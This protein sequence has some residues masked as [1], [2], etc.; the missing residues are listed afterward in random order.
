MILRR[1]TEH[2]KA[3]NWFAVWIDFLIVVVGVF[4]GLQVSNWN[5]ARSRLQKEKTYLVELRGEVDAN[6]R[7]L[8]NNIELM[9]IVVT[10]GERAL[11]FLE[12]D[13]SCEA[14]C[15]RL[16]VD[17][18]LASQVMASPITNTI[19]EEM[20]R[21]GLPRSPDIRS[22]LTLYSNN[23]GATASISSDLPRYRETIRGLTSVKAHRALW[24]DC[25]QTG[26]SEKFF[27]DCGA[28]ISEAEARAVLEKFQA[29]LELHEQLSYWI[30]HN[31][32]ILPTLS[33]QIEFGE[34]V[35]TTIDDELE[36]QK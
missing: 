7:V 26:L 17:F 34:A 4:V 24:R 14:E 8:R 12:D 5:D 19:F 32:A 10:S 22:A 33:D 15:W 23:G 18:F 6:N 35:I 13:A 20:Q 3:Q 27:P 30:G 11:I 28:G 29:R 36:N 2:V 21:L 31:I 25:H 16:L 1:I 9:N